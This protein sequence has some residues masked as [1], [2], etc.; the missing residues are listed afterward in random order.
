MRKGA[1]TAAESAE[2]AD[3]AERLDEVGVED[4]VDPG[5]DGG[6]ERHQVVQHPHRKHCNDEETGNMIV[7]VLVLLL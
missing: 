3:V 5:V 7:I 6:V 2:A 4:H 1:A